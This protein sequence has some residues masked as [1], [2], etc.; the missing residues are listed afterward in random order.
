MFIDV[1]DTISYNA[2]EIFPKQRA[3][4]SS[5]KDKLESMVIM[6][7]ANSLVLLVKKLTILQTGKI[8]NYIV[9]PLIFM[10]LILVLTI[11]KMI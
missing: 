11:L 1:S 10:I 9:Y 8:Q 2:N 5:T 3:Y 6:P 4:K 7:F